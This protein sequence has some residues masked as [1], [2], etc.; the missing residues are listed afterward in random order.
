MMGIISSWISFLFVL[1]SA[2]ASHGGEAQPNTDGVI[3]G[4]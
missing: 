2:D 1:F 4:F 3:H